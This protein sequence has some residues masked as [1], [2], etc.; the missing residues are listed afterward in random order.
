MPSRGTPSSVYV[1]KLQCRMCGKSPVITILAPAGILNQARQLGVHL[2]RVGRVVAGA[3][4]RAGPEAALDGAVLEGVVLA[5]DVGRSLRRHRR[6]Y[7]V[8]AQAAH[9][10]AVGARHRATARR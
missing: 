7:E 9:D 3:Q 5:R 6:Q 2:V 1:T 8:V 10:V 4:L